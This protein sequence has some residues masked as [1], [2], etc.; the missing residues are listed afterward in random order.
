MIKKLANLLGL[1]ILALSISACGITALYEKT[2]ETR[3]TATKYDVS[4]YAKT[5]FDLAESE[6]LKAETWVLE[7]NK[8]EE[9]NAKVALETAQ[10]N[11]NIVIT[12]GWPLYSDDLKKEIDETK[13]KSDE[14]KSSVL[15]GEAYQNGEIEYN[16]AMIALEAKDYDKALQHLLLSKENYTLAYENVYGKYEKSTN[17]LKEVED[18]IKEINKIKEEIEA[19]KK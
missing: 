16:A 19:L 11:Y 6:F 12:K 13:V 8:E 18:K 9:K 7:E 3:A 17:A 15:G 2:Q 4:K 1:I 14:I 5:E 10:T